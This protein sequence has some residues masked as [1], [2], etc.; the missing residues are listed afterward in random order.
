MEPMQQGGK[1][2]RVMVRNVAGFLL[3]VA[4]AAGGCGGPRDRAILVGSVT[5][6]GQPLADGTISFIPLSK[7][8][9][10]GT[11]IQKGSYRAAVT[12]GSYRVEIVATRM[13]APNQSGGTSRTPPEPVF[14]SIIP[15]RYNTASTL[16]QDVRLDSTRADFALTT[17]KQ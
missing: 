3:F 12:P 4:L 15:A 17:A 9:S 7:T 2:R 14:E 11:V 8:P 1:T 5:L 13:V 10:S 6:D 16:V